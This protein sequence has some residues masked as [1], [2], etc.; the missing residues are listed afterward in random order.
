MARGL[1]EQMSEITDLELDQLWQRWR[2]D[3]DGATRERLICHYLPVVEFL[4]GRA[5]RSVPDS[6]RQD[7]YSF[8]V[9]GLMDAVDKFRPELGNRFETY[10]SRRIR[11]AMSDGI[12][13]LNWL[14]R[15]A[16]QAASRVI[17]KV[18]TVDFQTARTPI[19]QRLDDC[20]P[21]TQAGEVSASLELAADYE[22]VMD[23]I[24]L[25][26]ERERIVITEHYYNNRRLAEIGTALGVTE[27]RV[28]QLH[29]RALVM[30]RD[31][32]V[33]QLSA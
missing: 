20:L 29:R 8:G 13:S 31:I 3:G 12:R 22:E 18:V 11:G 19:G 32:L 5:S 4:A 15:R 14:P 26:P 1:K 27:S 2:S 7:L 21:D 28:C 6:H 9:L 16:S 23:A 24:E 10:G 25:L 33:Q 17:E 30:L